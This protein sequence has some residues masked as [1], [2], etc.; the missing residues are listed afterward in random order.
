MK[1]TTRTPTSA[2]TWTRS[3]MRA[4]RIRPAGPSG[5]FF[6]LFV[7]KR[8][9]NGFNMAFCDGS[10][11][12]FKYIRYYDYSAADVAVYS[13]LANRCDGHV[14][15]AKSIDSRCEMPARVPGRG[16]YDHRLAKD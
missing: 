9:P 5:R 6:I 11:Q 1:A 2:T 8:P 14:I 13:Y 3:A 15:D 7:G 12:T 10:V 16:V 4:P